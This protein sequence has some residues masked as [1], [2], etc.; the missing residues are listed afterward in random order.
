MPAKTEPRSPST[1]HFFFRARPDEPIAF[2][3]GEKVNDVTGSKQTGGG[4]LI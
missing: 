4:I 3:D 2:P 1:D